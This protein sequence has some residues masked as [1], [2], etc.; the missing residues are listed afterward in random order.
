MYNGA[1][2][3]DQ[4]GE[5]CIA[6]EQ[7]IAN[8]LEALKLNNSGDVYLFNSDERTAVANAICLHILENAKRVQEKLGKNNDEELTL[9]KK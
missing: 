5:E 9:G 3:A 2:Y 1:K 4:I 6:D 8:M 7:A